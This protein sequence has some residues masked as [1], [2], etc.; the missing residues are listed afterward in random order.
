MKV[1]PACNKTRSASA[2]VS[3]GSLGTV[4][5]QR[6]GQ[7]GLAG[8]GEQVLRGQG[9]DVELGRFLEVRQRFLKSVSLRVASLEVRT[10]GEI[11]AFVFLNDGA[12]FEV[13][14]LN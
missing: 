11:A 3:R 10:I 14:D 12:Q 5:L 2:A 1:N 13:H 7:D 6:C 8:D 4:Y 9:F